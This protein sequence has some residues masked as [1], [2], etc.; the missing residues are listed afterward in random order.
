MGYGLSNIRAIDNTIYFYDIFTCFACKDPNCY[1]CQSNYQI[2]NA[3]IQGFGVQSGY[4]VPCFHLNCLICD[5][6]SN[7]CN[8]CIKGFA[9][10]NSLCVA[11][12]D[13]NCSYCLNVN[14]C[15]ICKDPYGARNGDCVPCSI[16]HFCDTCFRNSSIS[17]TSCLVGYYLL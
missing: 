1:Y 8:T 12:I 14:N 15:L 13:I 4:C 11:C 17:C 16:A 2:C 3:C 7:I 6:N 9:V 10:S 5:S